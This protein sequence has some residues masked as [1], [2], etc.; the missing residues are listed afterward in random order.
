MVQK[1]T[2]EELKNI[3]SNNKKKNFFFSTYIVECLKL[4]NSFTKTTQ[5]T[6]IQRRTNAFSCQPSR[7]CCESIDWRGIS[8]ARRQD[9]SPCE[10]ST[11]RRYLA[12]VYRFGT[13]QNHDNTINFGKFHQ[14]DRTVSPL[15]CKT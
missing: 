11:D 9:R 13:F 7:V 14:Q 2:R 10:T 1:N 4:F 15:D 6:T 5:N 3:L 12:V 8:F